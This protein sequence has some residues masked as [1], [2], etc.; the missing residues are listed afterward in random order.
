LQVSPIRG[1]DGTPNSSSLRK[2]GSMADN[3]MALPRFAGVV[4]LLGKQ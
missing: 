1:Y 3:M 2:Q 4:G